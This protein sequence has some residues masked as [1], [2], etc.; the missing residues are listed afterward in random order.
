M[1]NDAII[2]KAADEGAEAFC[3]KNDIRKCVFGEEKSLII[4]TRG[5]YL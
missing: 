4:Q 2:I 5:E 1:C 3:N